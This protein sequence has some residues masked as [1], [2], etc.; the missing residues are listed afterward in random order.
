MQEVST[1]QARPTTPAARSAAISAGSITRPP[2][3]R[4]PRHEVVDT[5]GQH[6]WPDGGGT[7]A[8]PFGF[9]RR[10]YDGGHGRLAQGLAGCA[11]TGEPAWES[12]MTQATTT[13]PG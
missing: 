4:K 12:A 5:G 2:A 13:E 1:R 6:R 3:E 11:S 7:R 8:G 10:G 9:G